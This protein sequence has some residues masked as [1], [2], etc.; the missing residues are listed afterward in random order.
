MPKAVKEKKTRAHAKPLSHAA[1]FAA[2]AEKK[3]NSPTVT[4]IHQTARQEET[5]I[6]QR[7]LPNAEL[8]TLDTEFSAD[9]DH[10]ALVKGKKKNKR[11]QRHER[12]MEK[13][14][15]V[16]KKDSKTKKKGDVGSL[17]LEALSDLLPSLEQQTSSLRGGVS[18]SS[19][20]GGHHTTTDGTG[21]PDTSTPRKPKAK[22][23]V[24]Q[25]ARRKAG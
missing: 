11:Q 2:A 4:A 19:A 1:R 16:Y 12:W 10:P 22:G 24:S 21:T 14:G 6:V 18:Q 20:N 9:E 23:P 17:N 13:L 25:S 7:A 8:L 3:A 5:F 15:G